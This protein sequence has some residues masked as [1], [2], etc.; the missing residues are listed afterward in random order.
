[1]SGSKDIEK[2]DRWFS[3]FKQPKIK[4]EGSFGKGKIRIYKVLNILTSDNVLG[5]ILDI[6]LSSIKDITK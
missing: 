1:M 6:K 2:W 4:W 3:L 5:K